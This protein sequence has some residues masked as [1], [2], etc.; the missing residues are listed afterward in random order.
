MCCLIQIGSL[1]LLTFL[2]Q[3]VHSLGFVKHAPTASSGPV[4]GAGGGAAKAVAST[5]LALG[6]I[7]AAKTIG[8]RAAVPLARKAVLP[9]QVQQGL[10]QAALPKI[11]FP[12]I[13]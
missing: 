11:A 10:G 6:T 1:V 9:L 4:S 7:T 13:H 8:S 2:T 3:L 12:K 5:A